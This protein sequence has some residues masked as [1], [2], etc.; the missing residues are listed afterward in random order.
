M[1]NKY[2]VSD[3][4]S[5]WVLKEGYLHPKKTPGYLTR[6]EIIESYETL[7]IAAIE[8]N[9]L[10]W[11]DT[12]GADLKKICADSGLPIYSYNFFVDLA[13]PPSELQMGVDEVNRL[14]DK[15]AEMGSPNTM[16]VPADLKEGVPHDEQRKWVVEG[17]HRCAEHAQSVGVMLLSE[18]CDYP[19]LRPIM[20]RGADCHDFCKAVDSPAYRLIYDCCAPLFVEEDSL[21][22]LEAMKPFMVHVHIKNSRLLEPGEQPERYLDSVSGKRYTGTFLD[23]GAVDIPAVLTELKKLNY[24]G[25]IS[26]EYQGEEDPCESLRYNIQYTNELLAR[27]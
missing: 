21:I 19:P 23:R 9:E 11:A 20:G 15:T 24:Q 2:T 22:T 5:D 27:E 4:C 12:S 10:Y 17:L 26:I 13:L 18:N 7:D 6:E 3:Y 1:K 8:L 14:I 25:Y 16:I